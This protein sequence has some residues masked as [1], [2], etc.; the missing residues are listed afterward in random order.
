MDR[1]SAFPAREYEGRCA[2]DNLLKGGYDIDEPRARFPRE[3]YDEVL[4]AKDTMKS[5]AGVES[6]LV[7]EGMGVGLLPTSCHLQRK[8]YLRFSWLKV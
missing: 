6:N 1:G 5:S 8:G 3:Q 7:K 2:L 4:G